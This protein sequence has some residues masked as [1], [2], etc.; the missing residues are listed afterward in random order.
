M[1]A[2]LCMQQVDRLTG[3]MAT[4]CSRVQYILVLLRQEEHQ[5]CDCIHEP[6]LTF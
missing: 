5:S 4:V 6:L 2:W 1:F 3:I